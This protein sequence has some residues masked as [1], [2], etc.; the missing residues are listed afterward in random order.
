MDSQSPFALLLVGQS[1]LARARGARGTAH[2]TVWG[3]WRQWL[4][5]HG[6]NREDPW[7]VLRAGLLNPFELKP[8][9]E[10]GIEERSQRDVP[11]AN[12]PAES[13]AKSRSDVGSLRLAIARV[14]LW[15]YRRWVTRK[16][17]DKARVRG[18]AQNATTRPHHSSGFR[19][20][21]N[22]II[23]IGM[24]EC[25]QHGVER[26]LCKGRCSGVGLHQPSEP[27]PLPGNSELLRRN[28]QADGKPASLG[29][30]RKVYAAS[31]PK[32]E[33]TTGP[34][35]KPCGDE[36]CRARHERGQLFVIPGC[37]GVV[38]RA[39]WHAPHGRH[40]CKQ[41]LVTRRG[42]SVW[43]AFLAGRTG[44]PTHTGLATSSAPTVPAVLRRGSPGPVAG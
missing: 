11:H 33:A 21:A 35:T 20:R 8:S 34:S 30:Q 3:D 10:Q 7:I 17:P 39:G 24:D 18:H 44:T 12:T 13:L 19:S 41:L 40:C 14:Q 2:Q 42:R 43:P 23:D 29:Q 38:T 1:T 27:S 6:S 25:G 28:V 9:F 31:A 15:G 22:P 37:V 16:R 26:P 32:F 36:R 5:A 4:S